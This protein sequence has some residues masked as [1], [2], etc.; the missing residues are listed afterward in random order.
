[1][2]AWSRQWNPQFCAYSRFGV[3]WFTR[4]GIRLDFA[5][6]FTSVDCEWPLRIGELS[7]RRSRHVDRPWPRTSGTNALDAYSTRF[8]H[9][10]IWRKLISAAL[11]TSRANCIYTKSSY[12]NRHLQQDN[13]YTGRFS[14]YPEIIFTQLTPLR[15]K[16]G[17]L[18]WLDRV[19]VIYLQMR[20]ICAKD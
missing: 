14:A 4:S 1:M 3:D 17:N 20:M 19:F 11:Q 10:S 9:A 18:K 16:K 8:A 12:L 2:P 13:W 15:V 6:G 7:P 5:D